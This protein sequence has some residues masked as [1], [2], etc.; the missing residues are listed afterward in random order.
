MRWDVR[1]YTL[2]PPSFAYG[3]GEPEGFQ[4]NLG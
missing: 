2:I 3:V 1:G 4:K